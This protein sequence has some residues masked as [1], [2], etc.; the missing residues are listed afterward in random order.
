MHCA[1]PCRRKIFQVQATNLSQK[2]EIRNHDFLLWDFVPLHAPQWTM[3]STLIRNLT[4][5]ECCGPNEAHHIN[6]SL[7]HMVKSHED[8]YWPD[9]LSLITVNCEIYWEPSPR[10]DYGLYPCQGSPVKQK[11][12]FCSTP[13][14]KWP[15]IR[16]ICILMTFDHMSPIFAHFSVDIHGDYEN[17]LISISRSFSGQDI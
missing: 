12:L 15:I 8:A 17:Y 4:R 3:C 11:K 16:P 10:K 14:K 6:L 1:F 7:Y 13:P 5:T 9:N 2:M